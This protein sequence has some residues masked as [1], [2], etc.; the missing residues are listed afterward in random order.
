MKK[1]V[2][3]REKALK[4]THLSLVCLWNLHDAKLG[5]KHWEMRWE[6]GRIKGTSDL[7]GA[8]RPKQ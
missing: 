8:Y 2:Q 1:V 6:S 5:E 7:V 4:P 3:I